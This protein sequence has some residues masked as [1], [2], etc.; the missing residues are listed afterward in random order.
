MI[1][2]GFENR[3]QYAVMPDISDGGTV[4]YV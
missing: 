1:N 4:F 3:R 2:A